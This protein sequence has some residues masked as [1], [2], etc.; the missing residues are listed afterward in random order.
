MGI[1]YLGLHA[2]GWERMT[3]TWWQQTLAACLLATIVLGGVYILYLV[4][5]QLYHYWRTRH[6]LSGLPSNVARRIERLK[7][8]TPRL[9]T[10]TAAVPEPRSFGVY[11][12]AFANPPTSDQA[13]LLSQWD[14]VVLDPLQAGVSDVLPSTTAKHILARLQIRK[15]V[16]SDGSP[17][18]GDCGDN[19]DDNSMRAISA[20]VRVL[21]THLKRPGDAQSFFTGIL[22][23]DFSEHFQPVI[24]NAVVSLLGGLG[25]T[26]WLE[27]GP[28][29]YP[30]EKTCRAIDMAQIRG[31][32]YRNG[33]ILANGDR[34]NYF[35]MAELRTVMRVVAAQ[36]PIGESTL[37]MWETVDDGVTLTHDVLHRS[38][39]WCNYNSAMSWIGPRSALTDAAV[40][41]QKTVLHEPIGALMWM[42]DE[43]TLAVHDF[44]RQNGSLQK[45]PLG[46]ENTRLYESLEHLVPGVKDRLALYPP[47][48]KQLEG[49]VFVIDELQWAGLNEPLISNPFAFSP[50]GHS[51]SG[52]GCFQLGLDC[53]MKDIEELLQAQRHTRDL[54]LLD[55]FKPNELQRIAGELREL[56]KAD[57]EWARP[58]RELHDLLVSCTGNEDDRLCGYSGLHSGFRTRLETQVWG[59]YEQ[60]PTGPLNIYLSGKTEKERAG[61]FLHT[62]MSS[63]GYTRY[64]CFMAEVA[65]ST[66]NGTLSDRWQLPTRIVSDIEQLT[67]TEAMLFLRRLSSTLDQDCAELTAKVRAC[68]EH[69]LINV[70]S[71]TQLRALASSEYLSGRVSPEE[72][73]SARLSWYAEQGCWAPDPESAIAL[74]REIDNRLP[75]VLMIGDART[76]GQLAAVIQETMQEDRIDAA[77]DFF[78]LA[79]FCA[80]RRLSFNEIYLEVLDRNPLPNGH[81]VQAAVFAELYALGARCD[82]FLDMTPNLL[83]KIISAKYRDYYNRHQPTRREE[84]FTELPTAYASMDIDL[85]PNGE[86]H[87]VPFYYRITFLGIFALPALID[88]MM[89]TTVGR[90]LYLTTFMSSTEKTLAT[91]ALMVALLVCGGFG[92]W[93]SSGGSYY[94]YA[95]GFPAMSMFVMTRFI[96]GLAV[97]LVGGLIAFICIC[98]IKSFAAGIVFFLYFFFLST[99]LM[100]LSVL[101]IYQLPG[102]QFQSGR[103]VIMS[104]VPIL[105]IGPIVTLWVGHDT[106]IY[107]CLLGVFVASLLLGARRII[108]RWNTW[109]LNIP[110]VTDGDVV[111]WYISSRPN[112]NVEEVSTSSTPRKALF[113][114]V[115]KE[116]RRRFW[117]KRTTDEF[118]R[119]M[120]DGYDATIFL[121]VWYCRYSRTKMPLPYSPTWNLQLKAAVDTLGD[122]QKGLRMHSAFL[123]WRHTGADVWCGILYFVI[124]LMDKWTALF[125][126][127]S[128]V[129]LST[130]SSSEYR[131]SVG[132]GLAYYLA[133]AVILDAV[134]QPL[135]TAVTQ[136]TPVPVKNLSTLR[137]VLSTNS[138]DRKRLYWSNLAK[139]FF[140]HI[141]GTAVTLALMWAFEASQNATIMF[142]AYIGSYSGLLFYQYNRIFTGPEAA[143]CL[144][145]GSVVGFVIGMT[146]HT[147]IASFTW[148]SVICLGSGTWTAAIYSLWLSDIG[149]PTFRPKNLSVLE[150]NSQKEL[151]TYTS[152]SLE[153][154]LDLSPTTVAETFDNIN[155][156]PDDLRH[157]LD[158]ETHPGI[159]VKEII[160]SNS[161]YRTSALVQAAFPD[162]AQFLREIARLWVSGQ[163]VIEFVSAEHLLQTEQRVR[164]I[165]RLT[166]DSLHIFIV[167]GPGLVGQDWTTNIR[168]NCRAIAE[169][170]VQA[171][172]EARLGLTHDESMMTELLIGTHQDNYDLSLP[173]G[174]KYQLE[175]SPAECA[176]VAKHGQRTFLRHLLLGIDCDLEWDELPKSARSFLLRRVAG[177]PGRLSSEELSWLQSRV[178]SEDIQN[179]AAHVARYNLGVAMSLGVWHYAQRWMEHDA[180]PSY[181]VFPDTT[182]EKPI[183]TLLPPPI[184]LHI[185]FTD[186]LKLSFLQVSHSVRTCLKFSIIALVADPQYQ[187]ELEYMLR[188][189]PLVFA[190]PMTLLLN[191]VWSFAKLLQRILIPLVLFYGRK[192]I[193]DVYKSSRGWK[194]VLHKNRVAIESLE[195]PTTCFAKSQGEGTTLLYQYSGSHMHEP[196]DNK[197]LKAINTYTDRLVL[198]KREEYRAGQ[199]INAFSYEYAQDTPKGRRT[200]PLPIQRLCT[201]GELEGQ[202]VIY[203]E[204]G[205][206]SSGSFMQGMN[207]VNFKY[208]F[209]KNAKFDDELLRAEYVFPHITIRV[210]WCM[211]PSRHPEKEDKWIPY[212]RVSQ[213]AFIEPGNVYQSKWTYDHKFHPV[214]TTTLNG[215]NVETPAM[216]SEDWFRVLDKP[217]RS[218]FL[219]DNPLFFFRSVRTNIVSRLLGLNVKTRPIPTSRARTHLWKAWKG[220]KTFDAVTTTWLDEILLRSDSILRPYWRNR[221]FGHLDAAGEYLDAQVDTILARVDIDPDISSWTQM[222]FKISDLYSFG[223]GGDARINTRTL[224]T[225]LQDTSTQLHV[226]AMDTATWPNEPGGVSACRRDMVNDLRGIRWHIISENANDY[227]VPK[228]QIERNVQSLTV[229][230]QWGL[231]FLNPTHGVFQNT[232]DSAVVERSQDTRKDDIKRHFVPILSRLVRC[233]RTANLKRHHIEEATNALVDLNTYFESGRSWNDVWMSKTVKTAWRELWLSDDVD[234]ALPVEKWWDAEHPS[235]QQL[236]TALD[237]WH[238]YLFIFSI[239]VPERIP[240]VFQVSH[241]FTGATYGVLCKAKRKCALHV[242]DHCISFREMTTFLSAAVSFDSSFV[243]TTLMSLGHLA[244]VLIEHHADVILPCAEYFN[245]GWEIEL[246][247]AEGALQHR[248]AF[249]RKIDPVVNGITNMERYKPIEKIRTETPTVVMLSHIRYVKDIKTAIMATDLIVNKW[250]FRDYRLHIYGDMERAPAYASECQ[251]IIASKGL[252][253]HVVLKGLGNPS[254]VLQDAWLFMNSSIS[255]GLP[256]AMGEAALTGVPVVCTDVGASFCVVTD[257][258]TG[259]RFSEVVA[260]NDS[261]SLAR[262]QLRVLALLDKWAPFAEDEPGTIVPT[263]DFHPT[264][265]QIKAVSE[266]MYAKIEQRR[267]FGMLGRANVLNSFSS[268]R[269]LRE[270]EQLLWIGKW[271]SRSFVTRTALSSAANLSTSAFFQMGKEKEKVNNSAVRLYIGNVPSTPDSIYQPVP[272]SPWRAW[273]DSRHASSS[274]TRTPV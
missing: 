51:Y 53:T 203:D 223:I 103:T 159:E 244:C 63:R 224:S 204:S 144:A 141:W 158:P 241:H 186:A 110:R 128:L 140:L 79:V 247:T 154:Y 175:R 139:F 119:R 164:A 262:A 240:D 100:L 235:L 200:R 90:G 133:G 86:Q 15:L 92:S 198:L 269:Y 99:Y 107:L 268:D 34:R 236:D 54:N 35:Q 271:Q 123:H 80:I 59:M 93:I 124:A 10:P 36:K 150:S 151:A 58:A 199:L 75:Q 6:E 167:I 2:T 220:S 95:M 260:P 125:T 104:C 29:S 137:E 219:H 161:G 227:G 145:A 249:A 173:E 243:N 263:L 259:K 248:K 121:L 256:L 70:P 202:V 189:Q 4:G 230:P 166:G 131:L 37:A 255:E 130:A 101:A 28:S 9:Y 266:R 217:Q 112:I 45:L 179:L 251:E 5:R 192:S 215:E 143:R 196:E 44:W 210:S 57:V 31:I 65:L 176:R 38:Y 194:T 83:G 22:L 60:D 66:A 250:G 52:L 18:S 180:Y 185:R 214:I 148:S 265:E 129:G 234:D 62:Y 67:P 76:L 208:A 261:D 50:D 117:S 229:L 152:S 61:T 228:F 23:A 116:R 169:A 253:E 201:A 160:L 49:Q 213:A 142:L 222:A 114:A 27:V 102:F 71:L 171:T 178:G 165:S 7:R 20:I 32:V 48:E 72:L 270:H 134:S 16:E 153:P 84:N 254:V 14:A 74:F 238:R 55:R 177:K 105:F 33:T 42:K 97:T 115:Q 190:V 41:A 242:W 69:C 138:G 191:S 108:A 106:V 237:M 12:G 26:V 126:G 120:A 147:V 233:A 157:K 252:R 225:Q 87:D 94:L 197:A 267:K 96:A 47:K 30:P 182:Y 187:R 64:Q 149:M 209:R 46:H 146:M 17:D 218:S 111:N 21:Q 19:G 56:I 113:E 207:P 43:R 195:G 39:K 73:V 221:D 118:V 172:A 258:N 13:R 231:D 174:V 272:V 163:T 245:P 109:Y 1:E 211:P 226:L 156:L 183:Q 246:G 205:Y 132:F 85:D 91:T 239:P 81:P 206:I 25:L 78:A 184:G 257:R 127:E 68:C 212:P 274:G 3:Q 98:C 136:R 232:L 88:I 264:P 89:L 8:E 273:R 135:W 40:A 77:A 170:V 11:L 181:P 155:A 216:I 82:L 168:R 162:A 193:S 122:M 188:G 24:L